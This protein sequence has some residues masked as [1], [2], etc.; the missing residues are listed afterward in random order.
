MGA[1]NV[2][3]C[4]RDRI[5]Y[6]NDAYW[7]RVMKLLLRIDLGNAMVLRLEMSEKGTFASQKQFESCLLS[8]KSVFHVTCTKFP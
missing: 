8:I 4:W 5:T 3:S 7:G 2:N 6:G 1:C